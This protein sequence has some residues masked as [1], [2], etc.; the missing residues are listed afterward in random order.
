[1]LLK[2]NGG[3]DGMYLGLP[4][5]VQCHC[6]RLI[7]S[8]YHAEHCIT[9]RLFASPSYW[10]TFLGKYIYLTYGIELRPSLGCLGTRTQLSNFSRKNAG[11]LRLCLLH[12]SS[13][14][15][16]CYVG[17][18]QMDTALANQVLHGHELEPIVPL[19]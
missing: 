19:L 2:M 1:M 14:H 16:V 13:R 10:L 4:I 5:E 7:G 3:A 11:C 17:C 9:L 12:V 6:C 15:I 18:E 8:H